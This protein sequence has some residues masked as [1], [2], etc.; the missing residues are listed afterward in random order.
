MT[1]PRRRIR[2]R[3]AETEWGEVAIIALMLA[4]FASLPFGYVQA[5]GID[6]VGNWMVPAGLVALPLIV[7]AAWFLSEHFWNVV[8]ELEVDRGAGQR[9]FGDTEALGGWCPPDRFAEI[10]QL[11]TTRLP[12]EFQ[13][14]LVER[15]VAI[16][17]ADADPEWPHALGLYQTGGGITKI[18][19][20][21]LNHLRRAG[22]FDQL[23]DNVAETLL[24]EVGHAFG[25]T[26]D[27]LNRYSIGNRPVPGAIRVRS[28]DEDTRPTSPGGRAG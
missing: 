13:H 8:D 10:V 27:D 2:E 23:E 15:N 26:E 14:G 4:V 28:L 5:R 7:V 19:I 17:T 3:L 22:S 1:R 21:R 6:V 9:W 12:V 16:T 25:M 20:F 11:A 18:T 24:H